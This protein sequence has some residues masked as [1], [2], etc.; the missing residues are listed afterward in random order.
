MITTINAEKLRGLGACDPGYEM[1]IAE[2]GE[3]TVALSQALESNGTADLFWLLGRLDLSNSQKEDLHLLACDYAE[4]ALCYFE[5]EFPDDKRPR[6]AVEAKRKW[7]R[8]EITDA[9]YAAA[10]AASRTAAAAAQSQAAAY[11]A[12][13]A[14]YAAAARTSETAA[15]YAAAE[16]A[17]RASAAA[18]AAREKHN[19]MLK[20]V[21]LKWERQALDN[22]KQQG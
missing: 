17:A 8:G 15:A 11:A 4:S 22:E 13:A 18:Y 2:H 3:E 20:S 16:K 12:Y 1:F 10:Y 6:N 14:A 19:E 7:V 21:L 5:S 9:A